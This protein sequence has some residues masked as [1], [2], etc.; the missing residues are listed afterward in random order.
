MEARAK[1]RGLTGDFAR[2][3]YA[4]GYIFDRSSTR[5]R[6]VLYVGIGHGLDALLALLDGKCTAVVGVD[7]YVAAD[8]NDEEDYSD[9]I[10]LI[11]DL[12]L[13]D[14]FEVHRK[15][16]AVYLATSHPVA[17]RIIVNDVLHHI[18]LTTEPLRQSELF[19]RVQTLFAMLRKVAG[20]NTKLIV[21]D[22]SRTGMR[23]VLGRLGLYHASIK[24]RTKQNWREWDAAISAAGWRRQC[25]IDYVPY[26]LRHIRRWLISPL[27]RYTILDKYFLIYEPRPD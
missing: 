24:Y 25:L 16:I 18:F 3:R 7:P 2:L 19:E 10:T 14:R 13:G 9:L 26:R 11:K 6:Y 17:D 22:V 15:T 4:N 1:K 5:P 23:P 27:W 20:S 12:K 8:G 21:G